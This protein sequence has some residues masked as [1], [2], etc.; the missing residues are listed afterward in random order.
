[1]FT[2]AI[3]AAMAVLL[4]IVTTGGS[5]DRMNVPDAV[6]AVQPISL[7]KD[8]TYSSKAF[9][10]E[11]RACYAFGLRNIP[12]KDKKLRLT[13]Y[14]PVVQVTPEVAV[15]TAPVGKGCLFSGFGPRNQ[16]LHKG[17][18]IAHPY[19]TEVMAGAAG[20]IIEAHYR[21]DYGNMMVID[22]GD[23]VFTRYAHLQRFEK[24]LQVGSFVAARQV[25]GLMG[26]TGKKRM[27][28]H[29]HYEILTGNYETSWKSF[30]LKPLNILSLPA[31]DTRN[32]RG[33]R[34]TVKPAPNYLMTRDHTH[35]HGAGR[36]PRL[37]R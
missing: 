29:L 1:M 24:N 5:V 14:A 32:R 6:S 28:R 15:A 8:Y 7:T 23:G 22:H 31:V 12:N 9:P 13:R 21:D 36:L 17:V 10:K 18:D 25:I 4:S 33:S 30:G 3:P 26:A 2:T 16:R 37:L 19:A 11:L 35:I 20:V 27:G 34:R